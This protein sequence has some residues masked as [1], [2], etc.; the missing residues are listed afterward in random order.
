M[1]D[2][3]PRISGQ[4]MVE[5]FSE[6]NQSVKMTINTYSFKYGDIDSWPK[7]RKNQGNIKSPKEQ[8]RI[9][10]TDSKE[11]EI[12]GISDKKF[13]LRELRELQEEK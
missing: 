5:G 12:H 3:L 4:L 7:I 10:M 11:M 2:G 13:T 9:P 6:K 1:P 8:N